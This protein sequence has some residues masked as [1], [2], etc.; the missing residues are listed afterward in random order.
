MYCEVKLEFWISIC[1]SWANKVPIVN[2]CM[3]DCVQWYIIS[4]MC[5]NVYLWY[6]IVSYLY[7]KSKHPESQISRART[8]FF[9][10][11]EI[12][13]KYSKLPFENLASGKKLLVEFLTTNLKYV[14]CLNT[15]MTTYHSVYCFRLF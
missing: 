15:F 5:H 4:Q 12:L 14:H 13:V 8:S 2:L 9:T 10:T 1:S 3:S 11:S 6:G 7:Y